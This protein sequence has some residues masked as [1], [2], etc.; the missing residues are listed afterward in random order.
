MLFDLQIFSGGVYSQAQP[1]A[2]SLFLFPIVFGI[3]FI[4]PIVRARIKAEKRDGHEEREKE[5]KRRF[6]VNAI[7]SHHLMMALTPKRLFLSF[8]LSLHVHL[9]PLP[10]FSRSLLGQ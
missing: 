3:I 5:R 6:G 10:F 1:H 4:D 9:S 7:I 8:S 2:Q